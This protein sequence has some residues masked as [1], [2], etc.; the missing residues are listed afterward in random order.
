M[1]DGPLSHDYYLGR[2]TTV[3]L[4]KRSLLVFCPQLLVDMHGLVCSP[5]G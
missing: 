1:S 4:L 2:P 5:P 3:V